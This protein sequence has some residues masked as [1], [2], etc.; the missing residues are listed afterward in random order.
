MKNKFNQTLVPIIIFICAFFLRLFNNNVTS[1]ALDEMIS[2]FIAKTSVMNSFY[3][4][5]PPLYF[6][7]LKL[8]SNI[9]PQSEPFYRMLNAI[10]STMAVVGV[11]MI[12]AE[13]SSYRRRVILTVLYMM[14]PL[15]ISGVVG[16]GFYPF[17]GNRV[18]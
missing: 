17:M 4:N 13:L 6:F 3:Y 9:I 15:S 5:H 2:L 14:A 11:W 1:L 10:L 12:G 8:W 16:T 18:W 7:L